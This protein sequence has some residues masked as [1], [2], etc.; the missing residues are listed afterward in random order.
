L[1]LFSRDKIGRD[2]NTDT[3]IDSA[4]LPFTLHRKK[5]QLFIDLYSLFQIFNYIIPKF[6]LFTAGLFRDILYHKHP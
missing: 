3:K 6:V 5:P 1:D 4:K 2:A